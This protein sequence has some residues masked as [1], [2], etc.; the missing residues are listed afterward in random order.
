MN[1]ELLI[2]SYY[3]KLYFYDLSNLIEPRLIYIYENIEYKSYSFHGMVCISKTQQNIII[4]LFGSFDELF[5]IYHSLVHVTII[6]MKRS[7]LKKKCWV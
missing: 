7:K 5:L 1:I 3:N 2:V 4:I 6:L